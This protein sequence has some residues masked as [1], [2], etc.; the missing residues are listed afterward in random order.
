MKLI[1]TIITVIIL[2]LLLLTS[3]NVSNEQTVSDT[4]TVESIYYFFLDSETLYKY[5]LQT[6]DVSR[7]CTDPNCL[8]DS[9]CFF[10]GV[11]YVC[12]YQNTIYFSR[13]DFQTITEKNGLSYITESICSFDYS[14][15]K[16]VQLCKFQS[17]T[18]SSL[19]G[20]LEYYDGY[21]YFY[22][23]TP[24]PDVMEYTLYRVSTS[25]GNPENMGISVPMWHGS[26]YNDRLFFFD[27]VDTLYSTD[28]YG[29]NRVDE[30]ILTSP[31]RIILERDTSN[32]YLY[33]SILYNNSHE[34]WRKNL[35]SQKHE[36]LFST[37]SGIVS[38]MYSTSSAV[39]FLIAGDE[40]TYGK[41]S[42][43]MPLTDPYSG[44]IYKLDL[45]SKKS[46]IVY[47]D[48]NTHILYLRKSINNI[49]V[50]YE[51]VMDNS[52]VTNRFILND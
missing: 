40:I 23:S 34:I 32:G 6:G 35:T 30:V 25:G 51:E 1:S 41:T 52:I 46:E 3:C 27:N 12:A 26:H 21:I 16:S 4:P 44:K 10:S 28:I 37:D 13:T 50:F 15:G 33:Y 39:Y 22:R 47:D 17:G 38:S 24:D 8:H 48:I 36:M 2:L 11:N 19:Q 42:Y 43:G 14:T 31:G 5:N 29:N 49:I 20:M 18:N 45:N 7:V 9:N